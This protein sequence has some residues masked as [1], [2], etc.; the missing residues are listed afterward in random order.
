MNEYYF[1]CKYDGKYFGWLEVVQIRENCWDYLVFGGRNCSNI[2]GG[3][4]RL[5]D[6]DLDKLYLLKD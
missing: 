5:C 1:V 2:Y 3:Y 4:C 6:L